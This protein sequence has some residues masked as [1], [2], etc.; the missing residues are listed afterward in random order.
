MIRRSAAAYVRSRLRASQSI[1]GVCTIT[2]GQDSCEFV[3]VLGRTDG[4]AVNNREFGF[5]SNCQEVLIQ[6]AEYAPAGVVCEPLPGDVLTIPID[7]VSTRFDV[8]VPSGGKKCFQ[9]ADSALRELRVHC[10]R[11]DAVPSEM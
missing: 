3:A 5:E 9:F 11:V 1:D 8:R 2:R 4:T 10:K 7:G 6:S